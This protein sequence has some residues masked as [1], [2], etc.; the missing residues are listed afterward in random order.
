M[1]KIP[2]SC[3]PVKART[4]LESALLEAEASLR[5]TI[6][7]WFTELLVAMPATSSAVPTTGVERRS[8][9]HTCSTRCNMQIAVKSLE[10]LLYHTETG[11]ALPQCKRILPRRRVV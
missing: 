7:L 9:R 10:R 8:R 4:E 1:A 6:A 3:P 11:P 5:Q 2:E